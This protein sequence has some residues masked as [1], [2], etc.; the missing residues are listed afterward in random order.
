MF[1]SHS[2]KDL[3]SSSLDEEVSLHP[4]ELADVQSIVMFS[5]HLESSRR[6]SFGR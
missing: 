6:E 1:I 4:F 3:Q 2:C 5:V